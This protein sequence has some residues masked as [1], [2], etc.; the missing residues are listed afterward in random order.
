M[1][2]KIE[3]NIA[4]I[5]ITDYA[6]KKLRSIVFIELPKLGEKISQ[7]KKIGTVESIKSVS[8]LISPVSGE[9][10]EVNEELLN[11]P[12]I[13]N[14]NPYDKG[15]IAKIKLESWEARKKEIEKLLSAE[16]YE[17]EVS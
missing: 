2:A 6:Q 4:T 11:T 5:G 14:S 17:K 16:E 8:E 10:V 3:D 13:I 9:V 7:G 15:W 12:E 1:W